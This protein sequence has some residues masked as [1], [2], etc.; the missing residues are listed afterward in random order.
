MGL[1]LLNTVAVP[2]TLPPD[3]R[4]IAETGFKLRITL[5]PAEGHTE[6]TKKQPAKLAGT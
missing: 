1:T 2:G 6:E 4:R 5:R 3:A